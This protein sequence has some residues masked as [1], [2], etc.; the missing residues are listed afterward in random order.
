MMRQS[1][2]TIPITQGIFNLIA[3]ADD[4]TEQ[5]PHVAMVAEGMDA[6]KPSIQSALREIC[7]DL[8]VVT[9]VNN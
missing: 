1:E 4:I 7:L 6:S 5:M 2:A 8:N 3:Y 9:V